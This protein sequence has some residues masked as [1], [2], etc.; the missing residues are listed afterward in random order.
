MT[1]LFALTLRGH[2]AVH[3]RETKSTS[4]AGRSDVA[5]LLL[6]PMLGG[7][8]AV[9]LLIVG[10][11]MLNV[12]DAPWAHAIGV[13]SLLAFIIVAFAALVPAALAEDA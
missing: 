13:A 2:L 7:R 8:L 3:G 5:Q 6:G 9:A 4:S 1:L 11:G 10:I 12:A